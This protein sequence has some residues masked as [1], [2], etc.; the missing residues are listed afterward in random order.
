MGRRKPTGRPKYLDI[1]INFPLWRVYHPVA[2]SV[3]L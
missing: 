1:E 2:H 3:S